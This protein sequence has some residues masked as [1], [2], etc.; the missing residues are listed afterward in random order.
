MAQLATTA[1]V[2]HDLG[3]AAGFGGSLFGKVA[4]NPA[5]RAI[6]SQQERGKVFSRAWNGINIIDVLS[7]GAVATTWALGRSPLTGKKAS[8]DE[9]RLARAK[10]ILVTAAVASTVV[11]GV[12]SAILSRQVSTNNANGT[13]SPE[14]NPTLRRVVDILGDANLALNA[15]IITVTTFLA[16]KSSSPTRRF[17]FFSL[18]FSKKG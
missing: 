15:G 17:G 5:V 18:P 16:M 11:N 2:M 13:G 6:D 12:G 8:K 14:G 9:R 10:D 7:L 1:R 3:L 4:L